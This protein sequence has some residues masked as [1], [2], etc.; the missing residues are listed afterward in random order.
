M[1]QPERIAESG[2]HAGETPAPQRACCYPAN[3]DLRGVPVLV[4]GGGEVAARKVAALLQAGAG[5]TVVAPE[6]GSQ[7]KRLRRRQQ[8]RQV[9]RRFRAS[10]LAGKRIVFVATD[11][12]VLNRR[13]AGAARRRGVWVNVATPG[14]ASTL[15]VPAALHR[16]PLCIAISTGGASAGMARTLR[17][18][19]ERF[20]GPEWGQFAE[21]LEE[22]RARVIR[23]VADAKRRR[24]LLR[25]LATPGWAGVIRRY[26]A[27]HAGRKMDALIGRAAGCRMAGAG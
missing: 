9:A 26:G 25:R 23:E 11:D 4:V 18:R 5:V 6:F 27:R 14:D 12:P 15:Q 17:E 22:R 8:L 1:A 3:L 19:L 2:R 24:E 13:I 16:G 10:D 20:I 7:F 21:L